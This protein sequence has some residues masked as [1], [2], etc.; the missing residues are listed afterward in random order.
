MLFRSAFDYGDKEIVFE[1]R[2]LLTGQEGGL[3]RRGV[4]T[5]G[6]L[7][8]GSEGWMAI[9]S[10]GFQVYKGET[11]EKTMDEKPDGPIWDTQ[12]HM[13]NF[14][15][16]CKSR[17]VSDLH[18]GIESGAASAAMCHLA[19]ISYRLGGKKLAFP[20]T[21][22]K[23]GE[24]ANQIVLHGVH[25]CCGACVTGAKKSLEN[26][27]GLSEILVDRAGGKITLKGAGMETT[28]AFEALNAGGFYATLK[29]AEEKSEGKQVDK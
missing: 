11:N 16:V 4:N 9:D 19:N 3:E 21:G 22:A 27:P 18:A 25:L 20:S 2:G 6:N 12:P 29:P 8:Y 24:K 1:V 14:I 5:I 7:F 26:V 23:K 15:A 10:H 13:E 17:K 28:R